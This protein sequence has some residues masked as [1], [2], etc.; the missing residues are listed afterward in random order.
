M[1]N[2]NKQEQQGN[3]SRITLI[4]PCDALNQDKHLLLS[5]SLVRG[6]LFHHHP[7]LHTTSPKLLSPFCEVLISF[8]VLFVLCY[9][10]K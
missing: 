1:N 3:F 10:H 8:A 7:V 2:K 5:P 9:M 6:L 4:L